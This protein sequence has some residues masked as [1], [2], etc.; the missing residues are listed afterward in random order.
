MAVLYIQD[1]SLSLISGNKQNASEHQIATTGS[2]DS[3]FVTVSNIY[4][5]F[6]YHI[7]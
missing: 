7:N 2:T 4:I 3:V 6:K 5:I 1:I